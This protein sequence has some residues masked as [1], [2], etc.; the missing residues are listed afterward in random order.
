MP[1]WA[2]RNLLTVEQ[3]YRDV[4]WYRNALDR[5][6]NAFYNLPFDILRGEDEIATDSDYETELLPELNIFRIIDDMML[7][8]DMYGAAYAERQKTRFGL[9]PTWTRLHP[10]TINPRFDDKWGV[11]SF[12]LRLGGQ[13]VYNFEPDNPDFLYIWMPNVEKERGPGDGVGRT[14]LLSATV[15]YY[16]TK[17]QSGRF[18][19]GMIDPVLIGVKDFA[20]E[21]EDDKQTIQK[22]LTALFNRKP[23]QQLDPIGLDADLKVERLSQSFKDMA[24]QEVVTIHRENIQTTMGIPQSQMQANAANFATAEQDNMNFYNKT[25]VP[26]AE[27]VIENQLNER[28]FNKVGLRIK[29]RPERLQIFQKME[30]ERVDKLLSLF[31]AGIVTADEVREEA[32]LGEFQVPER[33][34][35][36]RSQNDNNQ[37]NDNQDNNNLN[38]QKHYSDLQL[39]ERK[40]IK[41]FEEMHIP[42]TG[43]ADNKRIDAASFKSDILLPLQIASIQGAIEAADSPDDVKAIFNE[44]RR[45][46]SMWDNYG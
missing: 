41:R 40:A 32:G 21:D 6:V 28:L 38:L 15:L 9:K 22:R 45:T 3:A 25:I 11:T 27:R 23:D 42:G 20:V 31:Q 46:V 36:N 34:L 24:M 19:T 1:V 2:D 10:K 5:R 14:A 18:A 43:N 30:L 12:E 35:D 44:A 29:Y 4:A 37:N 39:W 8:L 33:L 7:D 13:M 17:Y 26:F 16:I